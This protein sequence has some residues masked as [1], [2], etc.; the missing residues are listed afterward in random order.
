MVSNMRNIF[1]ISLHRRLASI[2]VTASGFGNL[3]ALGIVLLER[4]DEHQTLR[5]LI[6]CR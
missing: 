3:T 4:A 5:G 1:S 2:A 6:F